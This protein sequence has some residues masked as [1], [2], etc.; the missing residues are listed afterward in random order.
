MQVLCRR[1]S[2]SKIHARYNRKSFYIF[3]LRFSTRWFLPEAK[4]DSLAP[5]PAILAVL[6]VL[7]C[8]QLIGRLVWNLFFIS[9]RRPRVRRSTAVLLLTGQND[10][11]IKGKSAL[12][13]FKG[14]KACR[15]DRLGLML[16]IQLLLRLHKHLRFTEQE[17][18]CRPPTGRHKTILPD[19]YRAEETEL[20][21]AS[22]PS[23]Q[24]YHDPE[25]QVRAYCSC[26]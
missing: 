18:S 6:A 17:A 26:K 23:Q 9:L 2:S 24:P 22:E 11:R 8:N 13:V 19:R 25:R 15:G 10:R 12:W 16:R 20:L 3:I 21:S 5:V 4:K 7:L 14:L 1:R